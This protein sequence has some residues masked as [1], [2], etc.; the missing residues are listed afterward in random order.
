MKKKKKKEEAFEPK[1]LKA[2]YQFTPGNAVGRSQGTWD[3]AQVGVRSFNLELRAD[4]GPGDL[5]D[6]RIKIRAN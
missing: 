4:L 1:Q 5:S 6:Q 2:A 3:R